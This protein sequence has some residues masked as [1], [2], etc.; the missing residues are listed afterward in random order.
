MGSYYDVDAILADAQKVPC[1]FEIDAPRLGF[2]DG[3]AT[4][5]VRLTTPSS[6]DRGESADRAPPPCRSRRA[7][8]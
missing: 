7:R 4:R 8:S 2:L 3:N 6:F 5:D 1:T